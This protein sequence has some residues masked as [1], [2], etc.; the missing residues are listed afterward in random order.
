MEIRLTESLTIDL[1]RFYPEHTNYYPVCEPFLKYWCHRNIKKDWVVLDV[2]AHVGYYAMLFSHYG[3]TVHA[4][5]PTDTFDWLVENLAVYPWTNNVTCH[6]LALG[7]RTAPA[8]DEMLWKLWGHKLEKTRCDF[9]TVDDFV[10]RENLSRL[11]FVKI[12]VDGFDL[13]VLQGMERTMQML[14]PTIAIELSAESL[15][16]RGQSPAQITKLLAE[17]H[18]MIGYDFRME[19]NIVCYPNARLRKHDR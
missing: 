16:Q 17:R 12:D 14:M 19:E 11:D 18:Y 5:E 6:Q 3:G 15:R 1:K 2:G 13:D 8:Q 9:I 4:F 10:A 7:A